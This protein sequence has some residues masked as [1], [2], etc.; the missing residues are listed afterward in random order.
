MAF[1]CQEYQVDWLSDRIENYLLRVKISDSDRILEYI[2]LSEKI[3]FKDNVVNNLYRQIADHFPVL[4]SSPLFSLIS[5]QIQMK[6]ASCLLYTSPSPR[7][8][9]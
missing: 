5:H 7:D 1:L 3:N 9:G 8:R 4:Q 6:I 2:Q